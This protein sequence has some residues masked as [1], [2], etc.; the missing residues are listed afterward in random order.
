M[1]RL[2]FEPRAAGTNGKLI[3]RSLCDRKLDAAEF[4][5][6]LTNKKML[7]LMGREL[8][9]VHVGIED[10]RAAAERDI[11]ARDSEWLRLAIH[12]AAQFVGGEHREWRKSRR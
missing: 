4:P 1:P 12:R 2:S 5:L 10:R 11:A 8:G 9:A 3:V 7:R 6:N